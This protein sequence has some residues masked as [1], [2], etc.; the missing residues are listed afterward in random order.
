LRKWL[1]PTGNRGFLREVEDLFLLTW[2]AWSGRT[3]LRDGKSF[4][5]PR[6]GQLPDDVEMLRPELPAPASWAEALDRAGHLFGI[7]LPG[8]ALSARNLST[9]VEAVHTKCSTLQ[10]C[11]SYASGLERCVKDW[12]DVNDSARLKTAQAS[13]ELVKAL[14]GAQG[15]AMVRV[16]AEFPAQT[17]IT[18][19][20][21]NMTTA[22][23][24]QRQLDEASRW[25]VFG[26]VKTLLNDEGRGHRAEL[27]LADLNT[28]LSTDEINKMLAEGLTDLTRRAQD[29]FRV[30]TPPVV[31]AAIPK[32]PGWTKVLDKTLHL[33]D[34]AKV[35]ESLRALAAEIEKV[36]AGPGE[37]RVDV[38]VTVTRREPTQ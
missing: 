2:C 13:A 4:A 37:M 6:V 38:A 20:G 3:L 8:R 28:L 32:M 7:A 23:A 12:A 1:D 17:S 15:A 21:R 24:A 30:S 31:A 9:F 5:I 29:L 25:I 16:L 10:A 27:L 22:A 33:E 34:T 19:M 26:Q 36:T 35:A 14:Q 11:A 18:A